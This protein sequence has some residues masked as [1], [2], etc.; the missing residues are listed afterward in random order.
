VADLTPL[1]AHQFFGRFAQDQSE[2]A[3]RSV[4][5]DGTDNFETRFLLNDCAVKYGLPYAYAGVVGGEGTVM[6]VPPRRGPCLRCLGELPGAGTV[7]TCDTV[8]VFGPAVT[9]AAAI[10]VAD[11][12][13]FLA[14]RE[15]FRPRLTAFRL[16]SGRGD[17][18]PT[19]RTIDVS[20]LGPSPECVCC[21]MSQYEFLESRRGASTESL[22]GQCAVQITPASP[23]TIDLKSIGQKLAGIGT[24][25]GNAFVLRAS[26]ARAGF[27]GDRAE[28]I[29]FSDGRAIIRGT[30]DVS[31]A[32]SAYAQWVGF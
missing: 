15:G 18:P 29:L 9:M 28:L 16:W 11:L 8:G 2:P 30:S 14:D 10:Q 13:A 7:A 23:S 19:W 3:L 5:V 22:C 12:I 26:I 31:L 27:E 17:Q 1:N 32:R 21:G 4:I 25:G 24:I 6:F 20:G